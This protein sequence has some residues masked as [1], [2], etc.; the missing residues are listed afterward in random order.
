MTILLYSYLIFVL[1]ISKVFRNL[2]VLF[3]EI[4]KKADMTTGDIEQKD[5]CRLESS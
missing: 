2:I 4:Y 5:L 3:N 1:D